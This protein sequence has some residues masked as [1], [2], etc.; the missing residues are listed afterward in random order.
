[1]TYRPWKALICALWWVG[2]D[3]QDNPDPTAIW[4]HYCARC[5]I[6]IIDPWGGAEKPTE[7]RD[8]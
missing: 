1:M 2:H 7:D 4:R 3:E 6:T 5:G 8:S